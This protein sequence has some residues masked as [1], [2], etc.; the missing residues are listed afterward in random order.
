MDRPVHAAAAEQARVRRVHDR[1]DCLLRDVPANGLDHGE[2]ASLTGIARDDEPELEPDDR[3][4]ICPACGV[5]QGIVMTG[6]DKTAFV[7]LEC[8]FSDEGSAR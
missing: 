7:C 1:V 8:G 3:P 6:D 4:P 5:T 2:N